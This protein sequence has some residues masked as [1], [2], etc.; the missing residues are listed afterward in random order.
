MNN[1]TTREKAMAFGIL[2][3]LII[4]LVYFFGIRILNDNYE[5]YTEEL[6]G[7]QDRKKFLDELKEENANTEKEI[8]LLNEK[9]D[10]YCRLE[11]NSKTYVAAVDEEPV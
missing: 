1:L 4:F 11:E 9:K 6:K 10:F 7:L 3:I 5:K 8:K 2:L